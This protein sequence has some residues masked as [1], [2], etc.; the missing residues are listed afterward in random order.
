MTS[1]TVDD[2]HIQLDPERALAIHA[3]SARAQG[4][5]LIVRVPDRD[6][7]GVRVFRETDIARML[8]QHG[9]I[10][11]I[12]VTEG[13]TIVAAADM[14]DRRGELAIWTGHAIGPWAP[15]DI[16]QRGLGGS[17]TAAVRLAECLAEMGWVVTLYGHFTDGGLAG[18]VLLRHFAEFDPDAP[19]DALIGFRD[20]RLFDHRPN[21]RF[22]ALWLE[23][24]APAE[25]LT[26]A[27][28]ANIDRVCS[29]SHWH[30]G[31][32][33]EEHPWLDPNQVTA[34][35]NGIIERWFR[36][37]PAPGRSKRVVYSSSPDRGGDIVLECWP[38]IRE[39]VPDAELMLTYPRWFELCADQ[40][41][42]AN[43]HRERLRELVQQPGV[44]RLETGLGQK[45]LSH[46][47]RASLVWVNPGFYSPGHQRFCET[48][49]ISAMEAQAAGC[50]V[51]CSNWGAVTETVQHGTL[52]DGDPSDPEGAWRRAFVDA[53]VQGLTDENVQAAAQTV[54]PEL[55][56]GMDWRGAAEQLAAMLP[57]G[58]KRSVGL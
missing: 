13:G 19:L 52:I 2:L 42:A 49:C 34:C 12:G 11:E 16:V 30:R 55:M 43:Q 22:C 46:L 17:E 32:I 27:R 57:T 38:M 45:A 23:D 1:V 44:K 28:A 33:L 5:R 40:F 51:V 36:E 54:G 25:G 18:D 53:V 24:L 6:T 15:S 50:V 9:R 56:S 21:A 4:G 37:E 35:R 10:R 48:S 47:L 7:S 8:Q 41:A 29:V 31:Q 58:R 3:A 26:P 39:E 20:A 14:I